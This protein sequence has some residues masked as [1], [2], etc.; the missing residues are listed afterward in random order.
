MKK[1]ILLIILASC[2]L[3][4]PVQPNSLCDNKDQLGSPS[5]N[6]AKLYERSNRLKSSNRVKVIPTE[7][8]F[9]EAYWDVF[10][11]NNKKGDQIYAIKYSVEDLGDRWLF[12]P[13]HYPM[14]LIPGYNYHQYDGPLGHYEVK[15]PVRF[16]KKKLEIAGAIDDKYF[17]TKRGVKL[18]MSSSEV[19]NIYGEPDYKQ[20]VSEKPQITRYIWVIY[21]KY[22]GKGAVILK[23]T[24]CPKIEVGA[25]YNI[26]FKKVNSADQAI[27]IHIEDHVL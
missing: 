10:L 24:V 18:G 7:D 27:I 20:V 1:M 13:D 23:G 5:E 22:E 15:D 8:I 11:F 9:I 12:L 16:F 2:T 21:D 17:I 26:Y 14:E 19:I 4:Q 25:D 3:E 6:I